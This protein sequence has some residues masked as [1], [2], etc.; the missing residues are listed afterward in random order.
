[1]YREYF[2]ILEKLW[3]KPKLGLVYCQEVSR[4]G[5][6]GEY[7]KFLLVKCGLYQDFYQETP[8]KSSPEKKKKFLADTHVLFW[9][10]GTPVFGISGDISSGFFKARVGSALFAFCGGK[11][12]VHS[13]DSPLVLH[14]PTSWRPASLLVLSPHTVEVLRIFGFLWE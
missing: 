3:I 14:V 1:M 4:C 6:R 9:A 7:H 2:K 8:V 12:N 13:R 5:T 10:T 11:C